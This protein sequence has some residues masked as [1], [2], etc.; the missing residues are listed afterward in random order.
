VKQPIVKDKKAS[1]SGKLSLIYNQNLKYPD[2]MY[3]LMSNNNGSTY[4]KC[5]LEI[6]EEN[7]AMNGYEVRK[8][9]NR[10]DFEDLYIF[11]WQ[12]LKTDTFKEIL[13]AF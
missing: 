7:L 1:S 2:Q 6:N 13:F 11:C 12:I 9:E 3:E 10:L 8:E 4:F 5:T